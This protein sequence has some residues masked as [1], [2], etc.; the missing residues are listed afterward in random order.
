MLVVIQMQDYRMKKVITMS[1]Q[2]H[3]SKKLKGFAE[4]GWLN[5]VGGCCGTTPAH[6]QAIREAVKDFAPRKRQQNTVMVMLYLELSHFNMMNRCV[7]Y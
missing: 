5:I 2:N 1:H 3:L 4:K 6:I 7:H